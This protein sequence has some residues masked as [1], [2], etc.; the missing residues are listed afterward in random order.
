MIFRHII[1]PEINQQNKDEQKQTHKQGALIKKTHH[2]TQL[3]KNK[4]IHLLT[5]FQLNQDTKNAKKEQS[6]K[7]K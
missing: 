6:I 4:H 3:Q 1:I 7:G 5:N 2:K